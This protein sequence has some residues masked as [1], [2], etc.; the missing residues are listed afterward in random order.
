MCE[1]LHC[2]CVRDRT[3]SIFT[4]VHKHAHSRPLHRLC[5]R[6]TEQIANDLLRDS[7]CRLT[8]CWHILHS[9]RQWEG[10]GVIFKGI[11]PTYRASHLGTALGAKNCER[12][13]GFFP[14]PSDRDEERLWA[15]C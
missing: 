4:L 15:W 8:P 11:C 7:T 5:L 12:G 14:F 13:E 9:W 10:V 6:L 1:W 3:G 2:V